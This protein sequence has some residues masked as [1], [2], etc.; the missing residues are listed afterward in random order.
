MVEKNNN[1][2]ES[3]NIWK[4]L[5]ERQ[6]EAI[7]FKLLNPKATYAEIS[8]ELD[9]P[10]QT[11]ANWRLCQLAE[12]VKQNKLQAT[13]DFM[14]RLSIKAARVLEDQLDNEDERVRQTAAKDILDRF[15]GKPK[16]SVD[17]NLSGGIEV[18]QKLY[19]SISPDNWTD[20]RG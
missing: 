12:R 15:M 7:S 16:Q 17:N 5:N 8:K 11:L 19:V 2:V 18:V 13:I 10:E 4:G 1:S 9:I 20:D 14:E 6:I 3:G